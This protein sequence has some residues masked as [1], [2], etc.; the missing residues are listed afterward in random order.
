[1][2]RLAFS[3]VLAFQ[4]FS[5]SAFLFAQG[6]RPPVDKLSLLR[7]ATI[8]SPIDGQ[9][10]IYDATLGKWKNG[11]VTA[12]TSFIADSP[13]SLSGG[14]LSIDLSA[15]ALSSSL[16]AYQP[17]T[18]DL[19]L[20]SVIAPS[21]KQ[22]QS[23]N[24]DLWS[25]LAPST[26]QNAL[27][28]TPE[29]VANKVTS[30]GASNTLYMSQKATTDYIDSGLGAKLNIV[31]LN[32]LGDARWQPLGS[33]EVTSN[34]RTSFQVAPDDTHYPS[35]KLVKDS[36]DA[37][38][39]AGSYEAPLS[40]SNSL[41]RSTNTVTLTNDSATPGNS[42]YY[43]TNGSA[44]KGYFD[45]PASD[46]SNY[47]TKDGTLA[48]AGFSSVTGRIG[49]ANLP[50][51]VQLYDDA[52]TPKL[53]ADFGARKLY[54]SDASQ[55]A[56]WSDPA[57]IFFAGGL[58][59]IY[60]DTS[61][62]D[63]PRALIR[64]K[65]YNSAATQTAIGGGTLDID[66]STGNPVLLVS[67][68]L[69][70]IA[71]PT[72]PTTNAGGVDPTGGQ[73][74]NNNGIVSTPYADPISDVAFTAS[75]ADLT[76]TTDKRFVTD[77]QLTKLGQFSPA[78]GKT[79]TLSNTLTLAGTDGSTLNIGAGGTL[80][81]NAFNSTA[82]G[83]MF[84]ADNLSGLANYATARSNL[85]LGTAAT[86][87]ATDYA[88]AAQ[89]VSTLS[90]TTP[91]VLYSTPVTFSNTA[92]A[93]S[94]A[95]SLINQTA[96]TVLAG[97]T[98]GSAA[99][100]TMRALV[101]ADI[102][103]L[104]QNTT[105]SAASLSISGQTGLLSVAGLTSTNRVMTVPDAPFTVARTDAANTF[106]G[107]QTMTSPA[108]TTPVITGIPTGT[109][110]ATAG[111]ANTLAL[112]DSNGDITTRDLTLGTGRF[113]TLRSGTTINSPNTGLINVPTVVANVQALSGA[114]AVN[115]TQGATAYTSTGA[116]QALALADGVNGQIKI[117]AHV[118]DG[119]S[120]V[121]TPTTKS[122]YSTITFTNVGDAVTL[123][124]FTTAGWIIT[125]QNGV[126]VAP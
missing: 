75:T 90:L 68:P 8:T 117:I 95:L 62:P 15:Y 18:A 83:D 122:G 60:Y 3:L 92:G 30:A 84:K 49:N 104:N 74:W 2:R 34:K 47:Q 105:G 56:D 88:T 86:T 36:L 125:G 28:Y 94:G 33:Y 76:D 41:A 70:V 43:G 112:R 85:G 5:V 118:S 51:G 108:L 9:A 87:A 115:V 98:T 121:L 39:A 37:K 44:T 106:T 40:F 97:P 109:G 71:M 46:L 77:A 13:L 19:D 21:T 48:L 89:G 114:G 65:N 124:F 116:A 91:S 66:D 107:V 14:H 12:G 7:D 119:G 101:A 57:N 22:N 100:P 73:L 120:G 25:V 103:T 63:T 64:V 29:D 17:H 111:T 38:Q 67:A 6:T 20:W 4:F 93:W 55:T 69:N 1:V 80:G 81:S 26:K 10:L 59:S 54:A 42:K 126:T 45:L 96:N 32:T 35:E 53:A 82:F 102:P 11:T 16:S 50:L 52:G 27:G 58:V 123:Q 113:I 110:V 99:A 23:A 78:T 79:F 61:D 24:L 31:D 72:L